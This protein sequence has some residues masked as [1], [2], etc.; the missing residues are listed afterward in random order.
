MASE[1]YKI[2]A[3]KAAQRVNALNAARYRE[4]LCAQYRLRYAIALMRYTVT[5]A[6]K[7]LTNFNT[8]LFLPPTKTRT[9]I[10][11]IQLMHICHRVGVSANWV[12]GMEEPASGAVIGVPLKRIPRFDDVEYWRKI[13]LDEKDKQ[14]KEEQQSQRAA[15]LF[16]WRRKNHTKSIK[17][18]GKSEFF[19]LP[20]DP[21]S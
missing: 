17:K 1:M 6:T 18:H 16:H 10:T 20:S 2:W 7:G 21:D 9:G 15:R 13:C 8:N 12:L 11:L 3:E 4:S 19:N 14:Q 5:H